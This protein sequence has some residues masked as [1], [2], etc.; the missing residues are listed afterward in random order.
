MNKKLLIAA[1]IDKSDKEEQLNY[2]SEEFGI[3]QHKIFIY[4][5]LDNESQL[6]FTFYIE[7]E[8]GEHINIR[9]FFKNALIVHKKSQTFYTIN[10]LNKLIEK[11]FDLEVGNIDYKKWKIDW[12]KFKNKLILN[13]NNNLVLIPLKRVFS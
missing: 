6:I 11:E 10:A 2:V 8:V 4:Q 12:N 3:E 9:D 7:L 13:S 5:D 1:F